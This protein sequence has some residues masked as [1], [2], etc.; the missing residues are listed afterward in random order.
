[1]Y[2][3]TQQLNQFHAAERFE[4]RRRYKAAV[5]GVIVAS[6]IDCTDLYRLGKA[7]AAGAALAALTDAQLV[8]Q[9]ID[10]AVYLEQVHG[11]VVAWGAVLAGFEVLI[12]QVQP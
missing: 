3:R 10:Y 4:L 2:T 5:N 1:M 12:A 7:G 11:V 9:A 6:P 8:V